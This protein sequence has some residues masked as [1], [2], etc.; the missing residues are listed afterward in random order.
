MQPSNSS[1]NFLNLKCELL[2][3]MTIPIL[4]SFSSFKVQQ[5]MEDFKQTC[6]KHKPPT[7][8]FNL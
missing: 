6:F 4:I 2:V 3:R 1:T 7:I 5:L 8:A